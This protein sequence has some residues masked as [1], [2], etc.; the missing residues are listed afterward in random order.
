M[1]GSQATEGVENQFI[2]HDD[3]GLRSVA[4]GRDPEADSGR[5]GRQCYGHVLEHRYKG[6]GGVSDGCADETWG[7]ATT[8]SESAILFGTNAAAVTQ[9][10]EHYAESVVSHI[11]H[12][13][14][15]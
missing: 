15:S 8:C 10:L 3:N 6:Y 5:N 1:Q 7:F 14:A 9:R 11:C 12:K 13:L 2:W 4:P